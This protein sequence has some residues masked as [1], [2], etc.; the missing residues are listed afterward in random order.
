VDITVRVS[1]DRFQEL[2][3]KSFGSPNAGSAKMRTMMHAINTGKIQAGEAGMRGLRRTLSKQ[4]GIPVDI[5][6]IRVGGKF[7]NGPF[8]PIN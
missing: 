7:D 2:I 3:A 6:I 8:I 4:L 5:S 1:P